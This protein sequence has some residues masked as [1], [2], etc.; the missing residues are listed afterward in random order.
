MAHTR[1]TLKPKDPTGYRGKNI[2]EYREF[3]RSCE[4]AFRLLPEELK[5]DKNRVI[6]L[7]QYLVG[8]LK[9]LWYA[10]FERSFEAC[11]RIPT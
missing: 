2:R 9:E 1:R 10:H 3:V 6:W 11:E 4:M 7:M 5:E 8:D